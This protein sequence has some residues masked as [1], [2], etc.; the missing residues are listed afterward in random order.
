MTFQRRSAFRLVERLRALRPGARSSRAAATRASRPPPDGEKP[1]IDFVVSGE[2]GDLRRAARARAAGRSTASRGF[3]TD[4]EAASTPQPPR[5]IRPL[6]DDSLRPAEAQ[7]ARARLATLLGKPIDVIETSRGC[8]FDCS[9]C[10]IIEMRGR[11]FH[12]RGFERVLADIKDARDHGARAIFI[13]DDNITLDVKRFGALCDAIVEAGLDDIEYVVQAMTSAIADHGDE[14]APKMRRAGFRYVFLGIEN[15][16]DEDLGFLKADAKNR[17]HENGRTV[18]NAT[19]EAVE[20]IHK[21]DMLVAGTSS[22][23]TPANQGIDRGTFEFARRYVD[24]PYIQHPTRTWN[25]DDEGA[26]RAR[27]DPARAAREYDGTTAVGAARRCRPRRSSSCA[28]AP[29]AG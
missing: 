18:G 16:L 3:R 12:R 13:V 24:W 28:G 14:L 26:A 17:R 9:F 8:T 11:N 10:S 25:A 4:R 20:H 19:L 21:N 22:S 23:A 5:P 2:G 1:G 7:G 6:E 29:S 15:I 27:P